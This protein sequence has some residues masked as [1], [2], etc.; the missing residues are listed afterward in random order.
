[1]K[2]DYLESVKKEFKYYKY[3]GNSTFDQLTLEE[4][5]W[6]YNKES[7][8]IAIIVKHLYGNMLSRWTD[9][10]N[11]DGEK[12]WRIR[13]AEFEANFK[14]KE[15]LLARWEDGWQCLFTG[16]ESINEENIDHIIYIRNMGHSVTEAINRQLAHY[17]YH[18][19]Q[20]VFIGRMIK[21]NDWTNLSIPV[22]KSQLYNDEKFSNQ[23]QRKHFTDDIINHT[24]DQ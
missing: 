2:N 11:S 9:F 23:K 3:L 12:P 22:G 15:D 13:D 1:V 20:I 19:G 10:L 7:N 6:Q 24:H 14:S 17:S 18:I 8:S 5:N 4:L 21:G 16:I